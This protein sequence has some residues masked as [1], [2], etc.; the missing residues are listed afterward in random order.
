MHNKAE[1][2]PSVTVT[3]CELQTHNEVQNFVTHLLINRRISWHF[4]TEVFTDSNLI[5][6][7]SQASG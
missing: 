4:C 7:K 1:Q 3:L 6:D 5:F 2:D